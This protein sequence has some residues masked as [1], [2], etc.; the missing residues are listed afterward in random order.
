MF[1][2]DLCHRQIEYLSLRLVGARS[3]ASERSGLGEVFYPSRASLRD[4]PFEGLRVYRQ[5]LTT[6]SNDW[7]ERWI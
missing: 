6:G 5:D 4:P 1:A 3:Y 7:V 2:H